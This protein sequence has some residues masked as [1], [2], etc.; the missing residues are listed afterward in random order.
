[1]T[2]FTKGDWSIRQSPL[3]TSF[4]VVPENRFQNDEFSLA[5][6]NGTDKQANAQL[7]AAAPDMY[8]MLNDIL[9]NHECGDVIDIKIYELLKKARGE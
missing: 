2:K 4:V 5:I 8:A 1:M 6:C 3:K 7:I 9:K